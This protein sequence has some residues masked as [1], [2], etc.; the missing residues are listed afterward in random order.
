M[1]L[2]LLFFHV[3][4]SIESFVRDKRVY[5]GFNLIITD[6]ITG[7]NYFLDKAKEAIESMVKYIPE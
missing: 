2:Q 6:Y 1:V 7:T 5:E 4:A 3:D